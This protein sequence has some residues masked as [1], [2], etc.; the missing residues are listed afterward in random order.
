MGG[1]IL[2]GQKTAGTSKIFSSHIILCYFTF[3][4]RSSDFIFVQFFPCFASVESVFQMWTRPIL[5]GQGIDSVAQ[6]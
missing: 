3:A 6:D 4:S 1:E 2:G 5:L